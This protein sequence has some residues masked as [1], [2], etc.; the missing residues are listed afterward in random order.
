[1]AK[2]LLASFN[3]AVIF[4]EYEQEVRLVLS[5][6]AES[7]QRDQLG[8]YLQTDSCRWIHEV[9]V[10]PDCPEDDYE[11]ILKQLSTRGID[12]VVKSPLTPHFCMK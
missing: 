12:R 9:V 4:H 1:M 10:N 11:E 2:I 3:S 8:I 7:I 6:N 5:D